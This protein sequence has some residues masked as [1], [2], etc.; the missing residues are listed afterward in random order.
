MSETSFVIL[1]FLA[2]CVLGAMFFGGLWWTIRRGVSSRLPALWFSGSLLIRMAV[3]LIGFY[4]VTR[5]DWLRLAA[6][7]TGFLLA[8]L[9][10]TRMIPVRKEGTF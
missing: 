8:R 1:A 2:G 9:A 10:V 3:I 5:G 4:Y 6:C 7:M